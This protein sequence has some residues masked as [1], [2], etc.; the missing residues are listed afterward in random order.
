MA[1]STTHS[2]RYEYLKSQWE[3]NYITKATLKK[4]VRINKIK[5]GAGITEEEYKEITGEDYAE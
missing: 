2:A 5:A 4:W 1:K 3:K